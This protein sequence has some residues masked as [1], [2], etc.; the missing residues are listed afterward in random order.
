M[1]M[2]L[3]TH[4]RTLARTYSA[5]EL[6]HPSWGTQTI[7]FKRTHNYWVLGIPRW[8]GEHLANFIWGKYIFLSHWL[9]SLFPTSLCLPLIYVPCIVTR[10]FLLLFLSLSQNEGMCLET[11]AE[12]AILFLKKKL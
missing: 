8:V 10:G 6:G 5:E 11:V 1:H 2:C 4:T 9:L 7:T 3:C 12:G